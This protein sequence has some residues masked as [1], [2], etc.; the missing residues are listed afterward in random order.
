MWPPGLRALSVIAA[1]E[2]M[3]SGTDLQGFTKKDGFFKKVQFCCVTSVIDPARFMTDTR[4]PFAL[5][6]SEGF[7]K[8]KANGFDE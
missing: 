2:G 6:L 4:N 8:L 1:K 7:D 5:S 3:T